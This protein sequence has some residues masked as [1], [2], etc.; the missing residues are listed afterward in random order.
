MELC[1]CVHI[2]TH[3]HTPDI[4]LFSLQIDSHSFIHTFH[5]LV[6]YHMVIYTYLIYAGI[7]LLQMVVQRNNGLQ[8]GCCHGDDEANSQRVKPGYT[9]ESPGHNSPLSVRVRKT[10][11]EREGRQRWKARDEVVEWWRDVQW[12]KYKLEAMLYMWEWSEV[13]K[14]DVN[15][16]A[17]VDAAYIFVRIY[18]WT[19]T[20]V[21]VP[22]SPRMIA[23]WHTAIHLSATQHDISGSVTQRAEW[24][25]TSLICWSNVIGQSKASG[26]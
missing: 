15:C 4:T 8:V 10:R 12:V 22:D 25:T 3:T 2:C 18:V 1:T 13:Y 6:G 7:H 11:G 20:T 21:S 26:D 24:M 23:R 16:A 9:E 14:A 17:R 5:C 19:H